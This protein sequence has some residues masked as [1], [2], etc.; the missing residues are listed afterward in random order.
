MCDREQS[1]AAPLPV[2]IYTN[3]EVRRASE[4]DHV[5]ATEVEHW[6]GPNGEQSPNR[7]SPSSASLPSSSPSSEVRMALLKLTARGRAL[8]RPGS[9]GFAAWVRLMRLA[10]RL[11]GDRGEVGGFGGGDAQEGLRHRESQ[12]AFRSPSGNA[13]DWTTSASCADSERE[14]DC[15]RCIAGRG[16]LMGEWQHRVRNG[17][18]CAGGMPLLLPSASGGRGSRKSETCFRPPP[19]Q[20]RPGAFRGGFEGVF[21]YAGVSSGGGGVAEW[22]RTPT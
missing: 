21:R 18:L 13:A 6:R 7:K 16:P 11:K 17:A 19:H 1:G 9:G 12:R 2:S 8:S 4:A 20:N 5:D 22:W 14:K 10:V 3:P 15:Y